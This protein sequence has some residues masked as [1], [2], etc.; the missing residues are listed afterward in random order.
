MLFR[1]KGVL[2]DESGISEA[3]AFTFIQRS[4]MSQRTRMRDAAEQIIA[5]NL[6]P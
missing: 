6:R 3:E 4:A 5:G 1:S 2:Q